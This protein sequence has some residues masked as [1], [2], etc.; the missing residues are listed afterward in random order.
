MK[1]RIK[2]AA[3]GILGLALC[4]GLCGCSLLPGEEARRSSPVIQAEEME[5]YNIVYPTMGDMTLS[6]KLS[7]V[8]M[9]V[10]E[11]AVYFGVEGEQ[12]DAI[13]VSPGDHV[14]AGQ[15]LGSLRMDDVDE[16]IASCRRERDKALIELDYRRDLRD[17]E[18]ERLRL[19]SEEG[20]PELEEALAEL[21]RAFSETATALTDEIGI[22]EKRMELLTESREKRRIYAPIDGTVTY[23]RKFSPT[24]VSAL[25]DKVVVV[26]DSTRSVFSLDTELWAYLPVGLQ[27]TI[28]SGR[29][30]YEAVVTDAASLGIE[31]K[32]LGNQKRTVYLELLTPAAELEAGDRGTLVVV[33]D[34]RENVL[35]ISEKAVSRANGDYIVYYLN[36]EGIRSYK[37]VELGLNAEGWYEVLGGLTEGEGVIAN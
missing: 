36:D 6:R 12:P 35:R 31:E 22:Y 14:N 23:V 9:P 30:E 25:T 17:L 24:A 20:T 13:L 28:T 8:Y 5:T 33:M 15:L 21:D 16:N 32:N 11:E 37:T 7:C 26:A 3:A 2:K 18:E 4:A 19:M 29:V 34:T 27:L 10:R 1:V